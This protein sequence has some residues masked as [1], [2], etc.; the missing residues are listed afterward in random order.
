MKSIKLKLILANIGVVLFSILLITI[1]ILVMQ[2][3]SKTSEIRE[4]ANDK[5]S[6]GYLNISLF[7][8]EPNGI[9]RSVMHYLNTHPD[10]QDDI[11]NFFEQL[12]NGRPD[13]SELYY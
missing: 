13:F 2:F 11:E 1:P 3:K 4:D 8:N 7:M 9:I 12:L 5:I 10:N 6:Q